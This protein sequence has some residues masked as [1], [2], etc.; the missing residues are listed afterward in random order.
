MGASRMRNSEGRVLFPRNEEARGGGEK[1]NSALIIPQAS[2]SR[3][4]ERAKCKR[5][6]IHRYGSIN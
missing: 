4:P 1:A 6:I 3:V 2:P 5:I